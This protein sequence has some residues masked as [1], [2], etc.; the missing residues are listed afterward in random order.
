M[1]IYNA[2]LKK[3]TF[4]FFILSILLICPILHPLAEGFI[5]NKKQQKLDDQEQQDIQ[6]AE[7][8]THIRRK[9]KFFIA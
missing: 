1:L 4:S 2:L 5:G 6:E 3:K 8:S 7:D 9:R